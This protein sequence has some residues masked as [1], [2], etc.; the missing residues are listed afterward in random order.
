[1]WPEF[2]LFK[3][4]FLLSICVYPI[5]MVVTLFSKRSH[6]LIFIPNMGALQVNIP[7]AY[8][9]LIWLSPS[10]NLKRGHLLYFSFGK[11]TKKIKL[12][13]LINE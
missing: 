8:I 6:S 10:P 1:M 7:Y 12:L 2:H 11:P 9:Q 4:V 5:N 13:Y 3:N